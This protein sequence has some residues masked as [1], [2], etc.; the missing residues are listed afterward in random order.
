MRRLLV[1]ES[2]RR[3][4]FEQNI[5]AAHVVAV[6]WRQCLHLAR[7]QR[8]HDLD[9][10]GR[11]DLALRCGDNVDAAEIG[12][13]QRNRGEQ[14][15]DQD[16]RHAY[17]RWWRFQYL[18]GGRQKFVICARCRPSR[19]TQIARGV[20]RCAHAAPCRSARPKDAE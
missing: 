8:L 14:T 7:Q 17:G 3:I 6:L 19:K 2:I 13:D 10:A 9:A 16:Q 4:K 12:P 15:D 11:L 20:R 18:E 1:C 5:G